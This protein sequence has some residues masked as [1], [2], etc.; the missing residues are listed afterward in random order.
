MPSGGFVQHQRCPDL[1]HVFWEV[2]LSQAFHCI[3]AC[4]HC[5]CLLERASLSSADVEFHCLCVTALVGLMAASELPIVQ[6]LIKDKSFKKW[7]DLYAKDEERFF[8]D[9]AD[10]FQ[11]LL[12]LG[13]PVNNPGQHAP[14]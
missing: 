12:H 2:H 6:A 14:A 13:V 8:D 3:R 7:V 5:F 10:A 11:K 4:P 9:F 1:H